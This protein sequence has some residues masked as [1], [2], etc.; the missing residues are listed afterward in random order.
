MR[1]SIRIVAAA[2]MVFTLIVGSPALADATTSGTAGLSYVALGDSFASG[3]GLSPTTGKPVE[4][5]QQASGDYPHRVAGSL[6]MSLTDA[7]C[8]GA[9]TANVTGK[10][11][12]TRSGTA[13]AQLPALSPKTRVVTLTI[14]GNDIGFFAIATG[15]IALSARGPVLSTGKS[16]CR[17]TYVKNGVD[18][19]AGRISDTLLNGNGSG[20]NGLTATFA[21]VKKAAPLAKV[22]V[23]GYPTI[24]PNAANTPANGCFRATVT[25]KDVSA[26]SIDNGL[27]F[28]TVDV[29]YLNSI[30]QSLDA[31][32]KAAA[33]TAGFTYISALAATAAHSACASTDQSYIQGVSLR[34]D[35]R[36]N[37]T[38]STGALHPNA[39][40]T[41]FM[42][43]LVGAAVTKAMPA[44]SASPAASSAS[45][46]A[47]SPLPWIAGG[48]AIV[49][50]A[51][52]LLLTWRR[53]RSE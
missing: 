22:F 26:L 5:C 14:G 15:C 36:L 35:A 1:L 39:R 9:V 46:F 30:E 38:L 16:N 49:L 7:S 41:A 20:T 21:A 4:G 2:A 42:A 40:G 47:T 19:L 51:I 50:L 34:S 24:L 3:L 12:K 25:G 18:S 8:S 17:S 27:P 37:V 6:G 53:R 44:K 23:V 10:P 45:G 33:E 43:G 13:P 11:Q 32:T 28:T 29:G 31:A 52:A 48:G